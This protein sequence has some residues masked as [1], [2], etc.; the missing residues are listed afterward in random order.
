M[1]VFVYGTLMKGFGN[2]RVMEQAKGK[3]IGKAKMFGKTKYDTGGFPAV[4][5][6]GG[7]IYGEVYLLPNEVEYIDWFGRTVR[8]K[9]IEI[10]DSLEGYAPNRPVANN[11]YLRKKAKVLLQNGRYLWVSYYYWN[12]PINNM[13]KI[14]SGNYREYR[15]KK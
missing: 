4:I 11:M 12:R 9:P 10:L 3:Y 5:D 1:Y 7:D 6:G 8:A 14:E 15:N 13:K 2:H